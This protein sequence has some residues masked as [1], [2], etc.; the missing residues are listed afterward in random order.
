[1]ENKETYALNECREFIRLTAL[2][3]CS[4]LNFL[5]DT[6]EHG[7][8]VERLTHNILTGDLINYLEDV[9]ENVRIGKLADTSDIFKKLAETEIL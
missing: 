1:M 4:D 7:G 2:L 6:H 5:R 9:P 8:K 3:A